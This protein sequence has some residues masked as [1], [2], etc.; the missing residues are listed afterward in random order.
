[1]NTQPLAAIELD[2]Q[3]ILFII[4]AIFSVLKWLFDNLTKKG[5]DRDQR[6]DEL[7][8]LY[9]QYREEIQQRQTQSPPPL[10]QQEESFFQPAAA[11]PELPSDAYALEE[12]IAPIEPS[13]PRYSAEDIE[14][15]RLIKESVSL[16]SEPKAVKSKKANQQSSIKK[17]LRS[18]DSLKNAIILQEVLGTPKALK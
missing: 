12:P 4:V 11:P 17:M 2:P 3:V 1:M 6:A 14:R 18:K 16:S 15:A 7:E 8:D 9:D 5:V 10:P 13:A